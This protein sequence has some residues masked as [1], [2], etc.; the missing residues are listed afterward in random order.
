MTVE[1]EVEK[2]HGEHLLNLMN[3]P[4]LNALQQACERIPP[5]VLLRPMAP[6]D[7]LE[8]GRLLES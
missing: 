5:Q 1:L 4:L 3:G 7:N 8:M 2:T 6:S